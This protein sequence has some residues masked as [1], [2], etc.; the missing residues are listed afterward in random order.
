MT[1]DS[2]KNAKKARNDEFYTVYEYI[3]KEINAYIEYNPQIFQNKVVLCPCDD[4]EWSNFTRFFAQNFEKLGLKKLICT[5][6]SLDSKNS[7]LIDYQFS[8][9]DYL[10][11]FEKES[12]IF[13]AENTSSHGKVFIL[14]ANNSKHINIDNLSWKYLDGDG[15][16]HSDEIKKLR[17]EA[18]VIVT[19]PPFSLFKDFVE[20]IFEEKKEFLIIGNM[21]AITYTEVFPRI[22]NNEMWLGATCNSEDMVFRVPD[23][24]IITEKDKLK[25]EKLGYKG[26]YTRLG[27]ANWYTNLDHG[28]RHQP[29][30]LMSML[31]NKKYSKHKEIRENGYQKYDNYDAIN[32]PYVDAIPKDYDNVMGVP[33]TFLSKYC[34]E[35]FEILGATESEGVGFSN[36]LWDKSSKISQPIIKGV[37]QYKRIFI[38]RRVQSNENNS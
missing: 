22:K 30:Q 5:S 2:L 13:N 27:N 6:Y 3:Q 29:L 36:G 9:E 23:G 24:A 20:W 11:S 32:I 34:P 28:R 17:E 10:T 15:D 18:D 8:L 35:Q 19:N 37:K 4:P 16:F 14:E 7:I 25:A 21:N 33:I 38:R 31:D 26:N 12:S 1:N